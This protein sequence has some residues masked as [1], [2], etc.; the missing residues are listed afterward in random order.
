VS[1]DL[2][3]SPVKIESQGGNMAAS[4]T[5]AKLTDVKDSAPEFGV[6]EIQELRIAKEDLDA[7]KT[8]LTLHHLKSGMRQTFGH[9][10][11]S[12]EEVYVVIGGSGRV[13]LDDEIIDILRLDSIR[14]APQ[15][16]RAF[17]AG[18]DGLE[19]LASGPRHDGDGEITP[20][21]W[22]D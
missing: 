13:K 17:E 15:V 5:L 20:N 6:G 3:T 1:A 4:Y 9:K 7:E 22:I 2:A 8:G 11:K 21:W 18:P 19:L 10:H 12:A 16:V 14:V